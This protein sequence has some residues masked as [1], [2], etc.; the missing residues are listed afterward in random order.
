[1][2]NTKSGKI[3]HY[4]YEALAGTTKNE[5]KVEESLEFRNLKLGFY[6]MDIF[7]P[8]QDLKCS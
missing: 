5:H 1:M 2:R 4:L 3:I 7:L 6:Y 8:M